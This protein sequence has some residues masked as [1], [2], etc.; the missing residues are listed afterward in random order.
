LN[1]IIGPARAEERAEALRLYFQQVPEDERAGRVD[2]GL[3]LVASGQIAADGVV[4]CR[5]GGRIVGAMV[6]LALPGGAG[7][8]W[9]PQ[10]LLGHDNVLIEDRLV[11]F[12]C[13]WLQQRGCK[14]AQALL[15]TSE[16]QI[17]EPL[18]RHGFR[19]VT[20]L[21]YLQKILERQE[22]LPSPRLLYQ[23]LPLADAA[24]FQ[25]TLERSYRHTLDCPELNEVR[26]VEDV[27]AGYQAMPGCR[28]DRWWLACQDDRP[29]GILITVELRGQP[30]WELLYVGLVPEARGRRLGQEM[31]R[32]AMHEAWSAGAERLTLTVDDRNAPARQTYAALGFE[33]F[34]RRAVLLR[35]FR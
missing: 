8:A 34:D 19:H 12:T 6:G 30:A 20:T 5:H 27:L 35:I 23:P 16:P 21:Y 15:A 10:V 25:Q 1:L 28:L 26:T 13:G 14:F 22:H 3:E 4:V 9:L 17:A 29:V 33:A 31:T 18:E 7:L 2:R 32:K 11:E 24:L